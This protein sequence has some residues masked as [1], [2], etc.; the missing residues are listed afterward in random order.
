MQIENV[1]SDSFHTLPAFFAGANVV[2][3]MGPLIVGAL[4]SKVALMQF[5][6][7]DSLVVWTQAF[8]ASK[9]AILLV[10]T[11]ILFLMGC[12]GEVLPVVIILIPTVFPVLYKMGIHPWWI[13]VYL[14]F[15]GAVGGLTPPVGGTLFAM[16][17]MAGVDPYYIF[18]RVVP[19]V[20]MNFIAIIILYLFPWIVTWLPLLVG[21]SQPPGF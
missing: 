17:G 14:I 20:I 1:A 4:L 12:I 7:A 6:V 11:F 5:H 18:R 13:C 10:V 8:G 19:W 16:A 15:I 9:L 21:F 3:F 2:G